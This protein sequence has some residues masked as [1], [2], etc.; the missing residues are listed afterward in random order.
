MNLQIPQ[1]KLNRIYG[2]ALV[3]IFVLALIFRVVGADWGM[4]R[5]DMHPDE[6]FVFEEAYNCALNHSFEPRIYYR[7]NHVSIKLNTLLYLGIQEVVFETR[8]LSDFAANYEANFALFTTASRV[9]T[10]LIGFGCVVWAFLIARFFGKKQALLAALLFAVF[11][12]FIEHSHYLTPDIPLLFFLMGALWAALKYMEKPSMSRL[13][14]MSFF[15]ALATCEKY[16]GL[17]GCLLIAVAV[18]VTRIKKPLLIVRDGFLAIIFVIL[19][20]LA[21]S[22]VLITDFRE[23]LA[24]MAGQNH[25]S[26]LGGDGLDFKGTLLYYSKTAFVHM[27]LILTLCSFYGIVRSFMKGFKNAFIVLV[28]LLY[29]VPISTLSVH[30][31]RYTL[32]IYTAC[33][34][35]GAFGVLYL[36]EDMHGLLEKSKVASIAAL[37]LLIALP[38]GSLSAQ[39]IAVT[40]SFLA[41]DSRVALQSTFAEVGITA[42]N[43]PHDCN[44][45]LDP[46]GFYGAFMHFEGC[47]PATPKYGAVNFVMTSSA[48]RDL[49][50]ASDQEAYQGIAKFYRLLDENYPMA[51]YYPVEV[52]TAHFIEL[53][54]IWHAARNVWRFLHGGMR[55]Y[56]IRLYKLIP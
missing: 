19:G 52:P 40:G 3:L 43:T 7:P 54:N 22:P 51:A 45:P 36:L 15:T 47:D 56:E 38:I 25:S 20:I 29:I 4:P 53:S 35:Y 32:P 34:F 8:G 5:R 49:F 50:L 11:P 6:G 27:G 23:V 17:Y 33:L 1:N 48:Q 26:H 10:A 46:G 13:F 12:A 16:P 9:L 39:A 44:T 41:P 2:W 24:V 28:F 14:F 37:L 30:W 55:G 31:E 42:D 21:V 18:I